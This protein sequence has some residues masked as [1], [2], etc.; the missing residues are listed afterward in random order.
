MP[1]ELTAELSTFAS[2]VGGALAPAHPAFRPSYVPVAP[3]RAPVER[4]APVRVRLDLQRRAPTNLRRHALRAVRRFAVLVIADLASFYLMREL[5]R[6]FR[7]YAVFGERL[8]GQV[9]A[10]LPHGTLNG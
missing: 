1:R 5:V 4:Q 2:L 7:D 8:S 9:E 6:L 3:S 10:T